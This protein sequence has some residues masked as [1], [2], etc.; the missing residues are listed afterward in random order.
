MHIVIETT[1]TEPVLIDSSGWLEYITDD[2]KAVLFIPYFV[3]GNR[4][5]IV[6]PVVIYEVR[7]ILLDRQSLRVADDFASQVDRYPLVQIDARI[8][9]EAAS[10]SITHRLHF[11]DALIYATALIMHA[12]LVTSDTHFNNLPGVTVL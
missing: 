9:L 10:L 8:A 12:E 7:K 3:A 4:P 1:G 6:S 2:T 5:L 11:A